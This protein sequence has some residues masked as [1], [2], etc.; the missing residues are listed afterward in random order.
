[1]LL[2]AAGRDLCACGTTNNNEDKKESQYYGEDNERTNDK[3]KHHPP[4]L[5]RTFGWVLREYVARED[6]R[7]IRWNVWLASVG[8]DERTDSTYGPCNC[9]LSHCAHSVHKMRSLLQ[10]PTKEDN[11]VFPIGRSEQFCSACMQTFIHSFILDTIHLLVLYCTV[12]RRR[13]QRPTRINS[14][15]PP[16][17]LEIKYCAAEPL[18]TAY[19]SDQ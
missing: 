15:A 1:V 10:S 2:M 4:S 11:R 13:R 6:S 17:P 5:A 18:Q 12:V 16:A 7:Q 8:S 14:T 3:G 19:R 9:V